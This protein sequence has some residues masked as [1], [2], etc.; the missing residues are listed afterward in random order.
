[1]QCLLSAGSVGAG[2]PKKLNKFLQGMA[3]QPSAPL[4]PIVGEVVIPAHI[5]VAQLAS[6]LSLKP[7][8]II[9]DLME[10][11]VFANLNH[12]LDFDSVD[13]VTRKH[14]YTAKRAT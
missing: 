6:A 5:T 12:E 2:R 7:F 9:A 4:P 1:M 14:G 11:G 13:K 3:P 10:V 8:R